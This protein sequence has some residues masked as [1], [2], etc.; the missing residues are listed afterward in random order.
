MNPPA[1]TK[2]ATAARSAVSF[3]DTR[4][5][6]VAELLTREDGKVSIYACGPT[7][8]D[9]PHIGHA[10]TALTYDVIRRY[11]V[12]R[13]YEV[14][15][16]MN[17]TDIDDKIINR[18]ADEGRTTEEVAETYEAVYLEQMD[19]LGI[20]R[21]DAMP[22]ATEYVAEMIAVISELVERD[23]GY[24]IDD[25]GVYFEVAKFAGYGQLVGQDPE[26]LLE[27]SGMRVE[28]DERKRS[29]QDFAL[30]KAAKPGEPSWDSPWMPG[31]P[32]WHIECVAMS[33]SLLG[34]GFDIHGGGTDLVFPHHENE[35]AQAEAA[36][37]RFAQ[38]WVHSAMVNVEGEKMA[39]SVGNFRTVEALLDHW[40]PD[41]VR[42]SMLQTHYRSTME[43]S[44]NALG[45][46]AEGLARIAAFL[47][48]SEAALA[49]SASGDNSGGTSEGTD[50]AEEAGEQ[51]ASNGA[52]SKQASGN[53][54]ASNPAAGD[55]AE[56]SVYLEAVA[57]FRSA[58]DD[59]FTTPKALAAVFEAVRRG[60]TALN[61]GDM[62]TTA[63]A[64][65]AVRELCEALGLFG[66]RTGTQDNSASELAGEQLAG[67]AEDIEAEEIQKLVDLRQAA[68]EA[69]DFAAADELRDRLSRE[70]QVDVED[71]PHGPVWRRIS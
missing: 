28:M 19:R 6:E 71:T 44:D 25:A 63:A 3:T 27:G 24:V 65:K 33:L 34:E 68:R 32:G 48:M 60:N 23:V 67:T 36:G 46:A 16:V 14:R 51:T 57:G 22:H 47:R 13:G 5:G 41:A 35:L 58:M 54:A 2:A 4:T 20:M 26:V 61:E 31:R 43:L 45:S 15:F 62:A 55:V 59:D 40:Q 70:F 39:K 49:G 30:W 8:Y 18:A 21:P 42:L 38:R 11:L 52:T 9:S 12:W 69:K 64:L 50:A 66:G 7:V 10:R 53:G 1:A 56:H 37:H 17:I 29:P